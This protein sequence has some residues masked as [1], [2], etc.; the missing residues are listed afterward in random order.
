MPVRV[1]GDDEWKYQLA[2]RL[3]VALE[4]NFDSFP[5]EEDGVMIRCLVIENV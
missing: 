4:S 5:V 3:D 1:I 2:S